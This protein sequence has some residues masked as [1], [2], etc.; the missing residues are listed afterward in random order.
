MIFWKKL[1]RYS[2]RKLETEFRNKLTKKGITHSEGT[3]GISTSNPVAERTN[4]VLQEQVKTF[5]ESADLPLSLWGEA[6]QFAVF[7]KNRM[8]HKSLKGK[9]PIETLL[10]VDPINERARLRPFGQNVIYG[11]MLEMGKLW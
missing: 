6:L 3:P 4:R 7:C 11:Y 8:P 5:L 1:L 2:K 9:T 10:G